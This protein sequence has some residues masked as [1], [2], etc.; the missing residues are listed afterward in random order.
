MFA[1]TEAILACSYF[2]LAISLF[3]VAEFP[4]A[5]ALCFSD[6]ARMLLYVILLS[7]I[8]LLRAL[9]LF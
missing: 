6:C 8:W 1:S 4:P 5:S 9:S 7:L 2:P 3:K